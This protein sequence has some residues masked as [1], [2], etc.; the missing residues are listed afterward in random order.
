VAF[1]APLVMD[2]PRKVRLKAQR[3]RFEKA[4]RGRL[5]RYGSGVTSALLCGDSPRSRSMSKDLWGLYCIGFGVLFH[6]PWDG[7]DRYGLT[8]T[9]PFGDGRL[10][11]TSCEMNVQMTRCIRR[12]ITESRVP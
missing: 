2:D 12:C 10:Y 9:L 3:R 5:E 8:L 1:S 11:T 7:S 4:G 6:G